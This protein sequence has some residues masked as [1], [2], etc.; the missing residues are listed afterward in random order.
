MTIKT[1]LIYAVALAAMLI[2]VSGK[3][4]QSNG[5]PDGLYDYPDADQ[6]VRNAQEAPSHR[7]ADTFRD[8]LDP[9]TQR[10][11]TDA[12]QAQ[13]IRQQIVA[14]KS[15]HGLSA[16]QGPQWI[17]EASDLSERGWII[18]LSALGLL[19]SFSA[20]GFLW[21]SRRQQSGTPV[22]MLMPMKPRPSST[23]PTKAK[24]QES[25]R[26]AA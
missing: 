21:W 8:S 3:A 4:Q 7:A 2:A 25:K 6:A 23:I 24:G 18:L 9:Q 16:S 5:S 10:M 13:A 14:R 12:E 19:I 15:A 20:A 17:P 26:R 11:K 22:A 1:S